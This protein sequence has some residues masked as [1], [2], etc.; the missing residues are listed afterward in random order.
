MIAGSYDETSN[1]L[2]VSSYELVNM[3]LASIVYEFSHAK[4]YILKTFEFIFK[5]LIHKV[6]KKMWG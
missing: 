4:Q 1:I 2:V 5:L 6:E 3:Y